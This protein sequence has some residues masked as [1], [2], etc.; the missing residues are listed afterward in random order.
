MC[1]N[2]AGQAAAPSCQQL[3][4]SILM[5][6]ACA[7]LGERAGFQQERLSKAAAHKA[8]AARL[9]LAAEAGKAARAQELAER[10]LQARPHTK[11]LR[12]S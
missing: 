3:K 11:T 4:V 10:A 9:G 6:N 2:A 7:Q 8:Q 12:P 1:L 5:R